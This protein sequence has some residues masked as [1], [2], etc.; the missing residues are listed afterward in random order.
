MKRFLCLITV[1]FL[2]LSTMA[3]C[4]KEDPVQLSTVMIPKQILKE[5]I[6]G[7]VEGSLAP[8]RGDAITP[9]LKETMAQY[10]QLID[11]REYLRTECLDFE[12]IGTR[13]E[14]ICEETTYHR[15]TLMDETILY[16]IC[17]NYKDDNGD[18]LI[19]FE[20]YTECPWE[21]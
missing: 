10:A 20:L 5:L 18:G 9:E 6:V 7:D 1:L 8:F 13:K 14:G 12:V 21:E 11:G 19:S 2:L 3:G 16:A 4:R 15:I 17:I